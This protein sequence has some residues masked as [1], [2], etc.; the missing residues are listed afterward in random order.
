[1]AARDRP[2]DRSGGGRCVKLCDGRLAQHLLCLS[3]EDYMTGYRKATRRNAF[4]L[5]AVVAVKS[6]DAL[7]DPDSGCRPG[8]VLILGAWDVGM[9]E[10]SFR[11][12]KKC[13]ASLGLVKFRR[14]E[15][16]TGGRTYATMICPTDQEKRVFEVSECILRVSW[17]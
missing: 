16:G 8:E 15:Y 17:N 6:R 7:R 4:V 3:D 2:V 9:S 11:T 13:L 10:A 1:M 12:A 14:G 5:L